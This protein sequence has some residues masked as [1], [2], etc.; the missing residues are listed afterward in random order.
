MEFDLDFVPRFVIQFLSIYIEKFEER[1]DAKI[2]MLGNRILNTTFKLP[3][4]VFE[5][6]PKLDFMKV[7]KSGMTEYFKG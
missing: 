2:I 3:S 5:C 1:V 6:F 4:S 7:R